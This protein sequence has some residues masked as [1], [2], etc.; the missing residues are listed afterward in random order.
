MA[1]DSDDILE[2]LSSYS[3]LRLE[4][5]SGRS[6][7]SSSDVS[8]EL[9]A[10]SEDRAFMVSDGEFPACMESSSVSSRSRLEQPRLANE[11]VAAVCRTSQATSVSYSRR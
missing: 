6:E 9:T 10:T 1:R 2:V 3:Y 5:Q 8:E 4:G 7:C 11:Y